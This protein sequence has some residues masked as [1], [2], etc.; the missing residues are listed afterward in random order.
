MKII[1][2]RES[3]SSKRFYGIA[4][5]SELPLENVTKQIFTFAH[6]MRSTSDINPRATLMLISSFF[7]I[8]PF[9]A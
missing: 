1:D 7:R 9:L 4:L 3:I 6:V 5:A 2:Q 8:F